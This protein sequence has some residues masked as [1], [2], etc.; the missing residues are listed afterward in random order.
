MILG[1]RAHDFGRKSAVE[2]AKDISSKGL[3]SIQLAL[4]KAFP[5]F[6][7][8]FSEMDE[9]YAKKINETFS[10]QNI[11]IAVLGCYVNITHP[12]TVER[13]ILLERFKMHLRVAKSFNCIV[14]GT[15]TGSM[16]ADYSF[17]PENHGEEAFN[18]LVE[19]VKELSEEA[20]KNDVLMAIEGVAN[21]VINTPERMK[22][23]LDLVDSKNLRVILDMRNY[24]TID[25]YKKY[26]DILKTNFELFGDRIEIIH[27]KD[28]AIKDNE[29]CK[30]EIG[31][32]IINFSLLFDLLKKYRPN[33]NVLIEDFELKHIDE[34]IKYL[35]KIFKYFNLCP[36]GDF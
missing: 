12:D 31:K 23:V 29:L 6:K 19:S 20:E 33:V 21:H 25:N 13:K 18:I 7:D 22:K 2:L 27:V 17:N 3:N 5:E 1:A 4:T 28:L 32:G 26:N 24:L 9:E 15:E 8:D 36:Q 16:N 11:R 30:V 14:V 35:K 34:S 10:S